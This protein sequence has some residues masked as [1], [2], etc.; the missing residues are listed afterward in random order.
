MILVAGRAQPIDLLD[1]ENFLIVQR[2]VFVY[3]HRLFEFIKSTCCPKPFLISVGVVDVH[4]ILE[5]LLDGKPFVAKLAFKHFPWVVGGQVPPHTVLVLIDLVARRM[6]AR[7]D[8]FPILK[9]FSFAVC[10]QIL[11][12]KV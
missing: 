5:I 2:G 9:I 6:R 3:F 10:L 8:L 4:M 1:P 12:R 7:V 11:H